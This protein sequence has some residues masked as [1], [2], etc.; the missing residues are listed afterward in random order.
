MIEP[1]TIRCKRRPWQRRTPSQDAN[2]ETAASAVPP[3]EAR[4]PGK[5][6]SQPWAC[7]HLL[8]LPRQRAVRKLPS[9]GPYGT[10]AMFWGIK[11]SCS[12]RAPP[13]RG[14]SNC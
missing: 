3:S 13:S 14:S 4:R 5:Q 7:H 9:P 1:F 8:T 11:E 10:R 2:V 12:P 6:A